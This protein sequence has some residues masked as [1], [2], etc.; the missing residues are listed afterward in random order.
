MP[1]LLHKTCSLTF[2]GYRQPSAVPKALYISVILKSVVNLLRLRLCFLCTSAFY[3]WMLN[4]VRERTVPPFARVLSGFCPAPQPIAV[5]RSTLV[6]YISVRGQRTLVRVANSCDLKCYVEFS[7][8]KK[9]EGG[10]VRLLLSE[11]NRPNPS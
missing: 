11:Q 8:R 2:W 4:P 5:Q 1:E 6:F 7:S 3:T 10:R 9:M